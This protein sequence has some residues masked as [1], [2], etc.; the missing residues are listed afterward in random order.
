MPCPVPTTFL[1]LLLLLLFV[2]QAGAQKQRKPPQSS[3]LR[4]QRFAPFLSVS[5]PSLIAH[6]VPRLLYGTRDAPMRAVLV[7]RV[8]VLP[9]AS[10]P[11]RPVPDWR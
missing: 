9:L 6:L 3:K 2:D 5:R 10:T 4:S 1:L 8:A 7:S 11:D